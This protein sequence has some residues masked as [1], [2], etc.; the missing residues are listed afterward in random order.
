V[1]VNVMLLPGFFKE[2]R[3]IGEYLSARGIKFNMCR[4]FP[5]PNEQFKQPRVKKR[6]FPEGGYYDDAEEAEMR[7]LLD[8]SQANDVELEWND[9]SKET[10][11]EQD[12]S[13]R[14][15][16]RFKDWSCLVGIER[17]AIG[18]EGNLYRGVCRM[19]GKLG[20]VYSDQ[21]FRLPQEPAICA[22]D[23]CNCGAEIN[24]TKFK[25]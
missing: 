3:E 9:G 1:V 5:L 22:N 10:V 24:V 12:V 8:T 2:A 14:G 25:I 11:S 15:L 19:G 23:S 4:I 20:N 7:A 6:V 16:N 21:G 17:L 13:R 18:F